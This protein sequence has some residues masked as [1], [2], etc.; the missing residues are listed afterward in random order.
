MINGKN[1]FD[2][3]VKNDLRTYD[4]IQ[5]IENGNGDNYTNR[6]LLDYLYFKDRCK[7]IAT[8]LSKQ[9]VLDADPKAIP[10][11][12]FTRNLDRD[13]NTTI[14]FITEGAKKQ[15]QIF[16]KDLSEYCRFIFV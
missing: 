7:M 9:Q 10:Q 6:C 11:I 13:G 3:L 15:F 5:S 1:V 8:D 4:N 14:F 2:Q 16:H 12:N